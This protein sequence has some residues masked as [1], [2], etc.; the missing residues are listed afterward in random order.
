M[1]CYVTYRIRESIPAKEFDSLLN[2]AKTLNM[3][4]QRN[5]DNSGADIGPIKAVKQGDKYE[6][7][8][9]D[10]SA[11][12]KLLQEHN[13]KKVERDARNR[14]YKTKREVNGQGKLELRVIG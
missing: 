11:I 9:T 2:A 8:S 3:R 10:G 14:G 7:S 13:I 12:R 4:V 1:P 5:A 6:L